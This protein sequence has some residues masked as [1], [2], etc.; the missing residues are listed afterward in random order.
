MKNII[1]GLRIA[2]ALVIVSPF[3]IFLLPMF[4]VYVFV[5]RLSGRPSPFDVE[6]M[7]TRIFKRDKQ[8]SSRMNPHLVENHAH[9]SIPRNDP[10]SDVQEN[11]PEKKTKHEVSVAASK[12]IG[13]AL[14]TD[15]SHPLGGE[16]CRDLA[17]LGYKVG[18]A[19]HRNKE[20]ADSVVASIQRMEGE[21]CAL[22]LDWD[23]PETMRGF[24]DDARERLGGHP[25][26][27][28]NNSTAFIPTERH[29]P[30]WD[31]MRSIIQVNLQGPIWLSLMLA[32]HMAENGGGQIIHLT[33]LCCER[34]L[35][36]YS[37]YSAARAGLIMATK[38]LASELE[39]DVRVNAIVP[40]E[41][42]SLDRKGGEN[43]GGPLPACSPLARSQAVLHALRYLLGADFV[44]GEI[45]RVDAGRRTLQVE[46]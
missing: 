42:M 11:G 21:A 9:H 4:I 27:L 5:E 32:A 28:V 20:I 3:I 31:S 7:L 37:T 46:T 14:V 2:L 36:G 12:S 33:D 38:A 25:R 44:T 15:G 39:P 24:V 22:F 41:V 17:R 19:W 16:I 30:S 29:S 45:L 35:K 1:K 10:D 43:D 34:P 13:I 26:L 6:A 8:L 18:V 23:N 40:G